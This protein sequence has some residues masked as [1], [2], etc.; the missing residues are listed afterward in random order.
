MNF[1]Y[2]TLPE[3]LKA[4]GVADIS[5]KTPDEQAGLYNEYNAGYKS[6]VTS[7]ATKAAKEEVESAW[8]GYAA[9]MEGQFATL[10]SA[11]ETQGLA[12]QKMKD[13]DVE[14]KAGDTL[15]SQLKAHADVLS[16]MKSGDKN[17]K[18]HIKAA[19]NMSLAGNVTGQIPQALRLAGYFLFHSQ[20]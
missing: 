2:Q 12:I 17:A 14:P 15:E 6:A 10:K 20:S 5:A 19:G 7:F 18:I 9:N 11:I 13:A 16:R 1:E 8:K 3:F 4:K